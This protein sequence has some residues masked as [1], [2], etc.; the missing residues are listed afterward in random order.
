MLK[1]TAI[2]LS[3]KVIISVSEGDIIYKIDC[4]INKIDKAKSKNMIILDFFAKFKL[5]KMV[6]L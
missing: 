5:C 2:K 6:N 3:A 1:I 4:S